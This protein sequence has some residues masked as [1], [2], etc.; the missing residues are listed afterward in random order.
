MSPFQEYKLQLVQL[1]HLAKDAIH[2]YIGFAC[3]MLAVALFRRSPRTIQALI[4]GLILSLM[5]EVLDLR[6]DLVST[7]H[8]RWS[9]S[10]KDIVNTNLIP[11]VLFMASRWDMWRPR[12][13][14]PRSDN[15]LV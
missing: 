6:D 3:F 7:G 9:A 10:L 4:P 8:L 15:S 14:S 12:Q 5:L 2:I 11:V 13:R 1:L